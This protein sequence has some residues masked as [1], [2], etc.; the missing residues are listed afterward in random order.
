MKCLNIHFLCVLMRL[1]ADNFRYNL[2]FFVLKIQY[3]ENVTT[4]FVFR[5]FI[6]VNETRQI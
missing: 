1:D 2:L 4:N 6:H 5:F 3:D